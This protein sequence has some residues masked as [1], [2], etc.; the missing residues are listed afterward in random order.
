[1]RSYEL[2]V[3]LNPTIA[4]ENVPQAIEKLN[5]LVA[6]NGGNIIETQQWGRRRL[7]YPIEHH[8]EGNYVMMKL[9]LEP[10][11]ARELE[12][13]LNLVE[14]YLRYLLLKVGD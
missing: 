11:K 12:A 13:S 10:S 6:K 3:I 7:S 2:T 8:A 4:E 5:A 9:G 14:E 1:M